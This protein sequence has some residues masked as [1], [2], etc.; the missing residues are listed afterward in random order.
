MLKPEDQARE[1]VIAIEYRRE[2]AIGDRSE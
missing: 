2:R 1:K